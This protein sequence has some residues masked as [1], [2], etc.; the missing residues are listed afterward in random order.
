M[1]PLDCF[2]EFKLFRAGRR[3]SQGLRK[4]M[5]KGVDFVAKM[6][7]VIGQVVTSELERLDFIPHG[8]IVPFDI[9][10]F[11]AFSHQR[12]FTLF[13]LPLHIIIRVDLTPE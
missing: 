11:I 7:V 4:L 2:F 9:I 12:S 1:E 3:K 8:Q 13:Q 6:I 5:F 10:D